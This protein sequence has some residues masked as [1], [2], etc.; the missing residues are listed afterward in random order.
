[1]L[2]EVSLKINKCDTQFSVRGLLLFLVLPD[3]KI[4]YNTT[5]TFRALQGKRGKEAFNLYNVIMEER[6]KGWI[7]KRKIE[8]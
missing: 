5:A 8:L 7:S 2:T 1:M 3:M 4:S 6:L